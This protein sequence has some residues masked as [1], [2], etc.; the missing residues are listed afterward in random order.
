[1]M[2]AYEESVKVHGT[3]EVLN[4]GFPSHLIEFE[5]SLSQHYTG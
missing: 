1:M 4:A 3:E 5:I 2:Y